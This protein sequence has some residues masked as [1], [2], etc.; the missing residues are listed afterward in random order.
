MAVYTLVMGVTYSAYG[1]FVIPVS[2]EYGLSRADANSGLIILNIG[3][4]VLSPFLG[5]ALDVI[6][7]RTIMLL[8]GI[9]FIASYCILAWSGSLWLAVAVYALI[10]PFAV[11]GTGTLTAPL[12]VARW[13][14]ANRARAM[15][16][17]QLG[18]SGGGLLIPPIV[19]YLI[20]SYGWRTALFAIGAGAGLILL[21]IALA[22]R[23]RPGPGELEQ[24]PPQAS[25]G[26]Q[27][28][29]RQPTEVAMPLRA[30]IMS[31]RFW[32]L[33]LG[34]GLPS[35]AGTG[36]LVSFV[37]LGREGGLSLV[38]AA[39]L[40]S[41]M[42]ASGIVAKVLIALVADRIDRIV[43]LT[44][45]FIA[46][47]VL[48]IGLYACEGYLP[49]LGVAI[50]LGFATS[51]IIPLQYAVAAERFGVA[52]FGV[53]VGLIVPVTAVL[54]IL[55]IRASGEIY[56]RTGGYDLMCL[57]FAAVHLIAAAI[58]FTLRDR[59]RSALS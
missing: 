41:A 37:P 46:G 48:N 26:Q 9:A 52:S 6:A 49:L 12:L 32:A 47:G 54:G 4:S 27:A 17:S 56:D 44:G 38:Q 16:L 19:G 13:F 1:L 21:G 40:I 45:M 33:S 59:K 34:C 53:V 5:R 23:E 24:A 3:V 22:I 10:L 11:K 36:L 55:S 7:A 35:A 14:T 31:P 2:E 30:V 42:S 28:D 20:A 50:G 25:T 15:T 43:L 29:D 58:V 18:Y 39:S 8:A 51:A 57:I